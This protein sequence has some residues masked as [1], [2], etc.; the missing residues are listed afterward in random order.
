[1]VLLSS[2]DSFP[3]G[4]VVW[5]YNYYDNYYCNYSCTSGSSEELSTTIP[6]ST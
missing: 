4:R 6:N 5:E 1:M 2:F 3:K